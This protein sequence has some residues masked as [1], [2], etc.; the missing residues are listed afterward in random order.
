L[1]P[2]K[3]WLDFGIGGVAIAL[4]FVLW[5]VF[6]SL[7][8]VFHLPIQES[9]PVDYPQILGGVAAIAIFIILR[10]QPKVHEF[11][12][13]VISELSKVTWP[14][15]KETTISTGVIIVMV[16]IASLI[17][18]GFDTV[19]GTLTKTFLEF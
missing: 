1:N 15:R 11:G 18:F 8:E 2:N 12:L 5:Q 9:W 4:G 17:L 10:R 3:K 6:N 16:G 13:E 7:W 14:T 19:W